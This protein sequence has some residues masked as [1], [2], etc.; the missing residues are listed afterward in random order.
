V[1]QLETVGVI[2]AT[3]TV[4]TLISSMQKMIWERKHT[5]CI[6]YVRAHSGL[7]QPTARGNSVADKYTHSLF[8]F[9]SASPVQLAED[10]HRNF[11]VNAGTLKQV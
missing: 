8:V 2:K 6:V 1:Q 10:F 7:S 3:S 4:C 5:F 11:H 9:M